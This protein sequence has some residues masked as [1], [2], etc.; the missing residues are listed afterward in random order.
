MLRIYSPPSDENREDSSTPVVLLAVLLTSS[1]FYSWRKK[2]TMSVQKNSRCPY[3]QYL[4][5]SYITPCLGSLFFELVRCF[6]AVDTY[7]F[8]HRPKCDFFYMVGSRRT[9][10]RCC[11]GSVVASWGT[12][13]YTGCFKNSVQHGCIPRS[14]SFWDAHM[15]HR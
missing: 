15:G 8:L 1:W 12:R 14:S 13:C 7:F 6:R 5:A 2:F 3:K 10:N 9:T 11:Q 4:K